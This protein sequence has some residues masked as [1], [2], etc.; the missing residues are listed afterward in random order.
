MID[1]R[2]RDQL[3]D[4]PTG[5]DPEMIRGDGTGT[6]LPPIDESI[7]ESSAP[8]VEWL[9]GLSAHHIGGLRPIEV[10][11]DA[12]LGILTIQGQRYTVDLFNAFGFAAPGTVLEI[13][14]RDDGVLTVRRLGDVERMLATERAEKGA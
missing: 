2:Q 7:P 4:D 1:P 8:D 12:G 14:R 13:E 3:P 9:G 11:I 6:S 10:S 5:T